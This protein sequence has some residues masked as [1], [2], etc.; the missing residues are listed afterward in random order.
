M[1]N[2]KPPHNLRLVLSVSLT[3]SCMGVRLEDSWDYIISALAGRKNLTLQG[4]IRV[5]V[6]PVGMTKIQ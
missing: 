1:Q 3:D 4:F 5:L 6:I 2:L